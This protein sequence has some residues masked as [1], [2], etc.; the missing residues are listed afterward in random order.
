MANTDS[1]RNFLMA[2]HIRHACQA[3]FNFSKLL[4]SQNLNRIM[5]IKCLLN[6]SKMMFIKCLLSL[7]KIMF[8]KCLL[9][10]SKI[11]ST[12]YKLM[13]PFLGSSLMQIF[14]IPSHSTYYICIYI[15]CAVVYCG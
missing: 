8:I 9:N 1:I 3:H 5:F 10:L 6:L 13:K 15:V 14:E 11:M 2:M 4:H 12:D 7:N